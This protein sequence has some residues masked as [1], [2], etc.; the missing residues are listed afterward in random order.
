MLGGG[1]GSE[2]GGEESRARVCSQL[3][4][5]HLAFAPASLVG[6]PRPRRRTRALMRGSWGRAA[7]SHLFCLQHQRPGKRLSSP[8]GHGHPS[9]RLHCQGARSPW[10]LP[11]GSGRTSPPTPSAPAFP[12]PVPSCSLGKFPSSTPP[13]TPGVV[14]GCP[15]I[16]V[17]WDQEGRCERRER[18]SW[19]LGLWPPNTLNSTKHQSNRAV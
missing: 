5:A 8:E 15:R 17:T 7:G 1:P 11:V 9:W 14:H 6:P 16:S 13:P 2:S 4:P 10:P 12:A 19:G 18:G 3:R